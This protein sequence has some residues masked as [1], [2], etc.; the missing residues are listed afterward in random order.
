MPDGEIVGCQV[1]L[2]VDDQAIQV[3]FVGIVDDL[4]VAVIF[5]HDYE[6]VIEMRNARWDFTPLCPCRSCYGNGAQ[7][8]NDSSFN[9]LIDPFSFFGESIG[10]PSKTNW[11]GR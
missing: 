9:H 7:S 8:Q 2:L 4:S 1:Y 11:Y 6:N 5:H 3:R 10:Q